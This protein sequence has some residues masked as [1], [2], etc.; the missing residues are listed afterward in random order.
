MLS[1]MVSICSLFMMV[2]IVLFIHFHGRLPERPAPECLPFPGL[3]MHHPKLAVF[4]QRE[5]ALH[6]A[7]LHSNITQA[8]A[9]SEA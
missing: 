2:S 9:T 7:D 8:V 5:S 4:V 3:H 1:M 6:R